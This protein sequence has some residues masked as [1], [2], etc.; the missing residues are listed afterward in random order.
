MKRFDL[1]S[2]VSSPMPPD[3]A[4]VALPEATEAATSIRLNVDDDIAALSPF[5]PH[6]HSVILVFPSFRDG[7]AFTQARALREKL[8]FTG[9]I[10]AEGHPL[11]DQID[12][13]RRCGFNAV[14]LEDEATCAA[15]AAHKTHFPQNY[16]N[17]FFLSESPQG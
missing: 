7:R 13:M 11:P 10:L 17:R 3:S 16:Q 9:E 6:L 8:K 4:A 2:C 1:K 15:W 5:L 14:L 12:F